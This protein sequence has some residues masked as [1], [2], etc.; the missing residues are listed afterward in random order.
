MQGWKK[1]VFG[2]PLTLLRCKHQGEQCKATF[3]SVVIENIEFR[4][5]HIQSTIMQQ[6][7]QLCSRII[8]RCQTTMKA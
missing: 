6:L 4:S 7:K 1:K 5:Q 8:I 3:Q 2:V